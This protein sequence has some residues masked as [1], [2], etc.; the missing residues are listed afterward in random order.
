MKYYRVATAWLLLL[1]HGSAMAA[2]TN[3]RP[4]TIEQRLR[5]LEQRLDQQAQQRTNINFSG[6]LEV[7]ATS[8][9]QQSDIRL[10]TVE[11]QL[12]ARINPRVRAEVSLLYEG[13]TTDVDTALIQFNSPAGQWSGSL[14][15]GYV[16]FGRFETSMIADPLPLELGETRENVAQLGYQASPFNAE[17]YIFNGRNKQNRGKDDKVDNIGGHLSLSGEH[18]SLGIGYINDIG[19]SDNIQDTI[20][21]TLGSNDIESQVAGI[22]INFIV[23]LGDFSLLGEYI[24]AT[25]KFQSSELAYQGRGA[26]PS[27]SQIELAYA[28]ALFGRPTTL[29]IGRQTS[30]EAVALALPKRRVMVG[31]VIDI[32]SQTSLGFEIARDNDYSGTETHQITGQLAVAF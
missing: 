6:L 23:R 30:G 17:L 11:I 9:E 27:A 4:A 22:N 3:N 7:E 12:S 31:L 13:E 19:E 25:D 8:T 5:Q 15:Q 29:A 10:A 14:G 24:S 18:Y 32:L 26:Q 16:P 21:A 2:D 1:L 28:F 20:N